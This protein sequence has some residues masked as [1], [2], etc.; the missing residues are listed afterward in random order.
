MTYTQEQTN[1]AL[2]L[3]RSMADAVKEAGPEGIPSGHLYAMMTGYGCGL[4]AYAGALKI[5]KG[6]GVVAESAGNLLTW[7]GGQ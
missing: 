2:L 5:L 4:S 6:A 1:A 7:K 3:V